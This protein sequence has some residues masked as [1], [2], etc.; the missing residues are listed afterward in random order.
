MAHHKTQQ[1]SFND[2]SR[3]EITK[4]REAINSV[5]GSNLNLYEVFTVLCL[6]LNVSPERFTDVTKDKVSI[7]HF[8]DKLNEIAQKEG[9]LP[10]IDDLDTS[11][12]E[13]QGEEDNHHA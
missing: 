6:L 3:T 11:G 1:E 7:Q 8:Q 2:W 5:I 4:H 12:E 10:N 9:I 13:P